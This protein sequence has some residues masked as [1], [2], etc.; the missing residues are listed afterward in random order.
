MV[1]AFVLISVE[2]KRVHETVRALLEQRGVTEVH[3][4]A[5]EYDMV[6]VIRVQ[7]NKDLANLITNTIVNAPGVER[8]KTLFALESHSTYDLPALFG[9]NS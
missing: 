3:V 1:T 7:D 5:G 8:T 2:D 4:V 9:N 6:A